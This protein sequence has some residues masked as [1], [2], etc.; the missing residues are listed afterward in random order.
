MFVGTDARWIC[1][2]LLPAPAL[3]PPHP[4]TRIPPPWRTVRRAAAPC[5]RQSGSSGMTGAATSSSINE[6]NRTACNQ[7]GFNVEAAGE[8]S[9][10][11]QKSVMENHLLARSAAVDAVACSCRR[12]S[13]LLTLFRS[14]CSASQHSRS[15]PLSTPPAAVRQYRTALQQGPQQ[16]L[17]SPAAAAAWPAARSHPLS[18]QGF[19]TLA[20]S[21]QSSS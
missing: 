19:M 1:S 21:P 15:R 10:T 2:S 11:Y 12:A 7:P 9:R 4:G 8:R 6:L 3:Q 5:A 16:P 13:C 18:L 14:C 17:P 20:T